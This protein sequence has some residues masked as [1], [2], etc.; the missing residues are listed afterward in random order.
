MQE[1]LY[2][3]VTT[4]HNYKYMLMVTRLYTHREYLGKSGE[5]TAHS[6]NEAGR[7]LHLFGTC[8]ICL[9]TTLFSHFDFLYQPFQ[10]NS[11]LLRGATAI[12]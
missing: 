4:A 5:T 1:G 12:F 11:T 8:R 6:S 3:L 10:P 2:Y 7:F 9:T